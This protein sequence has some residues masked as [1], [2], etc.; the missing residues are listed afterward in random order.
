MSLALMVGEPVLMI[1]DLI[2]LCWCDYR[3]DF[4]RPGDGSVPQPFFNET[5]SGS[6]SDEEIELISLY[7]FLFHRRKFRP[8]QMVEMNFSPETD[9]NKMFPLRLQIE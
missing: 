3:A 5:S 8:N 2:K 6:L 9:A 7:V 4:L 1:P